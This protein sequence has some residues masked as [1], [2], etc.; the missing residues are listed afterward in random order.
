VIAAAVDSRSYALAL[1][2]MLAAVVSAFLYLRIV[3]SMY[4]ADPEADDEN[5]PSVSLP[6]GAVLV[7]GIAVIFTVVV[8]F[9][10]TKII[11][12]AHDAV[13]VLVAAR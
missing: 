8:G 11:D 7:L 10:P 6:Y 2:A 4:L 12:F 13:P 1:V 3:V 5:R 9:V